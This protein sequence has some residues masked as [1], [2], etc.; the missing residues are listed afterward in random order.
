VR[1]K[2]ELPVIGVVCWRPAAILMSSRA[3][4]AATHRDAGCG[5]LVRTYPRVAT[6]RDGAFG[7]A[8][9]NFADERARPGALINPTFM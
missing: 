4:R 7:S 8:A 2:L 3:D 5:G 6:V 1:G 9:R